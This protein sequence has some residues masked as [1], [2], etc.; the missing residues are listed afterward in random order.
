V[1]NQQGYEYV[2]ACVKERKRISFEAWQDLQVQ[3][4]R[5]DLRDLVE[6]S[7][8][9][10]NTTTNHTILPYCIG[11]QNTSLVDD[12]IQ[13]E[14]GSELA[15][16]EFEY[17]D[18][19][20]RLWHPLQRLRKEYR[21]RVLAA[22]GLAHQYDIVCCAPTLL[23]QHSWRIPEVL[24]PKGGWQQGPMDLVLS[25]LRDYIPNRHQLRSELAERAEISI[26]LA[27]QIITALFCGAHISRHPT[28]AICQMLSGDQAR[29][30]FLKQ[31]PWLQALRD[32]IAVLWDYLNRTIPRRYT[33]SGRKLPISPRQKWMLYFELERRVLDSVR[34]YMKQR[35]IKCF[36]EHDGWSSDQAI[37]QVEL[38]QW[39][40]KST[41]F[42]VELE[43]RYYKT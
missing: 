25:T 23:H 16:A 34:A 12:W 10:D 30:E 32:D 5:D 4:R 11:S 27:K 37:D 22:A 36:L 17:Q 31:D 33:A 19:S 14:H 6:E 39:I 20:S 26:Q 41:G 21:P 15:R 7:G 24:G 18:I 38:Q 40:E 28:S 3:S 29:I 13:A 9:V 35:G 2:T 1:R 42:C 8:Y 43:Y